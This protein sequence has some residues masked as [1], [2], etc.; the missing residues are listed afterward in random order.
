MTQRFSAPAWLIW[1]TSTGMIVLITRNPIY[2]GLV[3]LSVLAVYL[4]LEHR[5]A[6]TLAW[7]TVLRIGLVIA[8]ISVLFNV[9][10]VHSGD[11]QFGSLPE[12]WP[13]VGGAL[14]WNAAV[15]GVISG[16]A[17]L[18]LLLIA[19]T[20]STAVDRSALVRM[21]PQS[22]G[23]LGIAAAAALSIFPQT[24][25]AIS[26]VR[27][28]H[29]ARGIRI[30]SHRDLQRLI[31]PVLNLGLERAFHLAESMES[32]AFGQRSQSPAVS[33]AVSVATLVLAAMGITF[34]ATGYPVVG[35]MLFAGLVA[36]LVIA[37]RRTSST[38][39][40]RFRQ[41]RL[42]RTDLPIVLPSIALIVAVGIDFFLSHS[43]LSYSTYP[44]LQLPGFSL[45]TAIACVLPVSPSL[46]RGRQPDSGLAHA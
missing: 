7:G 4:S 11:R 36:L 34:I 6:I 16:M 44:A 13:V 26:Q 43:T 19:A 18:A 38:R 31:V 9:L 27:E 41:S 28:A 12:S 3:L 29:R 10:T 39:V 33:T 35:A 25:Q 20:L 14:T 15:Y 1:T 21:V 24:I 32:R 46:F 42:N 2:L 30:S 8:G 22:I 37:V 23:T 45:L 17:L 5:S 40:S